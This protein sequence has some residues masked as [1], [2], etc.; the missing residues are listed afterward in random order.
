MAYIV[1]LANKNVVTLFRKRFNDILQ[2]INDFP[3]EEISTYVDY[4][5]R[6]VIHNKFI[7]RLLLTDKRKKQKRFECLIKSLLGDD[8]QS[9]IDVSCGDNSFI[10]DL[11]KKQNIPIV[12]GNDISWDQLERLRQKLL[13]QN[14]NKN[15]LFTN[16]NV[17]SLP[18]VENAFDVSYC[19]NTLH[20]MPSLE[21]QRS[22]L[23]SM[24]QVS[25]KLI[26][27]EIE[28]PKENGK[29][30]PFYLHKW[31]F[32]G[33]LKDRGN[34]YLTKTAFENLVNKMFNTK[35]DIR[36]ETFHNIMGNYLIATI[37]KKEVM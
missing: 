25:K 28:D 20:H 23:D 24:F 30:F 4:R 31:W 9:I 33:F 14:Y 7:K 13:N 1:R 21:S 37:T 2:K 5:K 10:F 8:I 22:L 19:R 26:L 11:G 15:V 3:D 17:A 12:V 6:Y 16:H 35:A 18:F 29:G 36:F 27:I 32:K 34:I